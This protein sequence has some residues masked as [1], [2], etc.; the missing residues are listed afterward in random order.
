MEKSVNHHRDLLLSKKSQE[1]LVACKPVPQL[2]ARHENACHVIGA[3][4]I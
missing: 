2:K 3:K 1:N 4:M